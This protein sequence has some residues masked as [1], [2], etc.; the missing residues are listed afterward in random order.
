L[1]RSEGLR[2][3]TNLFTIS[4]TVTSLGVMV[5]CCSALLSERLDGEWKKECD[6]IKIKNITFLVS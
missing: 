1:W 4:E 3:E 5:V 6:L 2:Y